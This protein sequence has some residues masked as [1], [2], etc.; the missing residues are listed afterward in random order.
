MKHLYFK[1]SSQICL[2]FRS[3]LA[4]QFLLYF[5]LQQIDELLSQ[6][7]VILAFRTTETLNAVYE[8]N[9]RVLIGRPSRQ[10]FSRSVSNGASRQVLSYPLDKTHHT[11]QGKLFANLLLLTIAQADTILLIASTTTPS[12]SLSMEPRLSPT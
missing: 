12:K 6:P 3:V 8:N 9:A 2:V 11:D 1:S 10:K 7:T 4:C 5:C